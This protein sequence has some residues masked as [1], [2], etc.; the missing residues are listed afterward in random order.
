MIDSHSHFDHAFKRRCLY[1]A[2][3]Q[4]SVTVSKN[5]L[6][7]RSVHKLQIVETAAEHKRNLSSYSTKSILSKC[8]EFMVIT[9]ISHQ[10]IHVIRVSGCEQYSD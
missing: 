4:S 8:E 3:S 5:V 6:Y 10:S 1:K 2:Q 9:K 7:I